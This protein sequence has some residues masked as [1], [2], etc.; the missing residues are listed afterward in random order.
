MAC[1]E[2]I[3]PHVFMGDL[4]RFTIGEALREPNSPAQR[5][6]LNALEL[7]M[8]SGVEELGELVCVSF[9]ENLVGESQAVESMLP[10]MGPKLR[11]YLRTVQGSCD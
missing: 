4:S 1:Y 8:A 6:I 9:L 11:E 2:G 3:L 5:G 7:A 10:M